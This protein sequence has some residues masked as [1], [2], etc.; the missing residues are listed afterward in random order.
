MFQIG[1]DVEIHPTAKINVKHGFIGD[2]TIIREHVVIEGYHVEIG[3][4][5]F[6]N[7]FGSIGGGS[8]FDLDT[9]FVVGDF[10]HMGFFAHLNCAR[11]LVI[12]HEV[13]FGPDTKV[14]THGA[15]CSAWEGFPADW[16]ATTIGDNVYIPNA[17]VN[18][19]VTIGD[20][21]VVATKSLINRDLPSGCF[22]AG[23]PAVVKTEN[24]YPV[25][26]SPEDKLVLFERIFDRAR[27]LSGDEAQRFDREADDVF[28]IAGGTVF[29]VGSRTID[30]P[31]T[32][33][34]ETLRN[35]LR[36]NG[37][38]FRYV[39]KKGEYAPWAGVLTTA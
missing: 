31:A 23:V 37:I 20:N 13:A 14:F 15:Y 19:G 10:L 4:E 22:A 28:R 25:R 11:P 34:S 5:G 1:Q 9:K 21:V 32:D 29:D 36:R 38:R 30:G 35:Q 18:P 33:F 7:R 3:A 17:W 39:V 12:G 26:L 2:R 6:V 8:S 24:Y 16:G 27:V